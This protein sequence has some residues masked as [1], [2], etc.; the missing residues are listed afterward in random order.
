MRCATT[1]DVEYE[2][3]SLSSN[4]GCIFRVDFLIKAAIEHLRAR[5][6]FHFSFLKC[7]VYWRAAFETENTVSQNIL[8][9]ELHSKLFEIMIQ[10]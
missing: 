9:S 5:R 1:K 10:P 6:L 7:S 3:V 8:Y 2:P 4:K